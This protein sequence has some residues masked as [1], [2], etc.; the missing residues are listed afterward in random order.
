MRNF[1]FK[2]GCVGNGLFVQSSFKSFVV[3][4]VMMIMATSSAMAQEAKFEVIDGLRY[5][6]EA[7][8]K[9]AS[10]IANTKE[11]YSGDIVV[12]EK[13]KRSDGVEY[14]VTSFGDECFS[15]WGV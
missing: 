14:I 8:T 11:K 15:D 7:D 3:M 6:L 4:V 13:I 10:L 2:K 9:T 1:T 5:L 12:P